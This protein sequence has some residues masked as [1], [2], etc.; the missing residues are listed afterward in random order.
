MDL[1]TAGLT[2]CPAMNAFRNLLLIT[3]AVLAA[4]GCR[5]DPYLDAYLDTVNAEKRALEDTIYDLKYENDQLREKLS[6]GAT[7]ATPSGYLAP[8]DED[9]LDDY[10][11]LVEPP[12]VGPGT[13][14]PSIDPP[15]DPDL[16]D[17]MTA[18][19]VEVDPKEIFPQPDSEVRVEMS[20]PQA[21]LAGGVDTVGSGVAVVGG[22][23][24]EVTHLHIN[25][26][27]TRGRNTDG[28]PG[29]DMLVIGL[30]PRDQYGR[31]VSQ[32]RPVS[33]VLLDPQLKGEAARVAQWHFDAQ[34]VAE[35]SRHA[36][37]QPMILLEAPWP[38]RPPE[39]GRLKLWARY[40]TAEGKILQTSE[41]VHITP[42]SDL[43]ARWTPRTGTATRMATRPDDGA[44]PA[45]TPHR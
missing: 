21:G 30:E 15:T 18:P 20:A 7:T 6:K 29:D 1:G 31:F 36:G 37:V 33:L 44:A 25:R 22:V 12:S 8:E 43:S 14:S 2:A 32:P 17:P 5:S 45:W 3:L 11:P 39:N 35:G 9:P 23:N 34:A 41:T 19:G 24:S 40:T 26:V 28:R 13:S 27:A 4:S 38:K 42:A 10:G 16:S